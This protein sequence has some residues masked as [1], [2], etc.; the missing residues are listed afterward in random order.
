MSTIVDPTNPSIINSL[1]NG[2]LDILGIEDQENRLV[3]S[4]NSDQIIGGTLDDILNGLGGADTINGGDGNDGIWGEAGDDQLFGENGDDTINGGTGEDI[5]DGGAGDDRLVIEDGGS[6]LT[7]G[8][9]EDIFQFNFVAETD[10]ESDTAETPS[11]EELGIVISEIVDFQP[12]VDKITIQGLGGTEAPIYN[13]DTGIFSLDDVEIAQL[14]ADLDISE[15]DIEIVGNNNRISVVDNSEATVYRFLDP[16]VGVH[17]YTSDERE[18][19]NVEENLDNYEFEGGSYRTVDPTTGGQEV[20][21]FFNRTTGVHLYTTNEVERDSILENLTDFE[22]EGVQFY[23]Y[24]TQ[25]EGS[26]PVY[27]FFEP[28]L[29][30][31]FYTPSEVERDS[32][33][34]NLPNYIF[35]DVAYYALPIDDAQV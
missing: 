8:A 22:F 16:A 12:G 26:I 24:E 5:L 17:F 14:A 10:S 20:Y 15:E 7:G 3:G 1:P 31:H 23:A 11:I 13:S 28:T 33:L 29:G 19:A 2:G 34:E 25:I 35:E 6:T 32:V 21:R 9:G 27:R 30:V 4:E 18:R